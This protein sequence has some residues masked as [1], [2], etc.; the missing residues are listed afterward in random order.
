MISLLQ[1]PSLL[2]KYMRTILTFSVLFIS[3]VCSYGQKARA[4]DLRIPFDGIPGK[5]NAIT[6]VAGVEVGYTTIVSGNGKLVKGTGPVRTGVTA[7]FPGGK[8]FTPVFANWHMLNG[9]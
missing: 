1:S 9:N 6:D 5:L 8:K 3:A 2:K 4:R 7:I